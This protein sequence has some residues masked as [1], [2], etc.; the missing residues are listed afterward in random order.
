MIKYGRIRQ[1]FLGV[2]Y[3]LIDDKVKDKYKLSVDYGALII[4]GSSGESAITK[5]SAAN[6][7]GLKEKDIILEIN[8]EKI[9]QDNSLAKIIQKYAVGDQIKIKF[10]RGLDEMEADTTLGER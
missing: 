3:V 9:T 6:K 10:L 2:R 5:D 7:A 1:P 8:L 4:K